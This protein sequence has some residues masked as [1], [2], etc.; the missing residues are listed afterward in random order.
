MAPPLSKVE[1]IEHSISKAIPRQV[2]MGVAGTEV[3][4]EKQ[5]ACDKKR[6]Y[7]LPEVTVL[8]G[9]AAIFLLALE[10]EALASW[11]RRM[12]V[13]PIQSA[14]VA[15]LQAIQAVMEPIGLTGPRRVAID[16]GNR[17]AH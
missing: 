2:S 6:L 3:I 13:S 1:L 10:S 9:I 14:G 8:L 15:A 11:V 5:R 4:A 16:V 12:E 7:S 17:V